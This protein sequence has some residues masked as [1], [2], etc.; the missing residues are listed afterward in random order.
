M[1]TDWVKED[2]ISME[3]YR[4]LLKIQKTTLRKLYAEL[5]HT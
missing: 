3:A 2:I 5:I 1:Q 4:T